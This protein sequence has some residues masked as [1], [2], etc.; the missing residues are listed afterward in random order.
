MNI[1]KI[2]KYS[3][4]YMEKEWLVAEIA[5]HHF[6]WLRTKFTQTQIYGE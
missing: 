3:S 2:T 5:A 1:W 6:D 4:S